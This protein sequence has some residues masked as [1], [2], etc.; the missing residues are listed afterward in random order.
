MLPLVGATGRA[1]LARVMRQ[2]PIVA[3]DFDG[4][5]APIVPLPQDA[6]VPQPLARR[7]RRLAQQ[8]PLAVISGR[9]AD[10]VRARLPFPAFAVVGL[11]GAEGLGWEPT[12]AQTAALDALKRRLRD[13]QGPWHRCGVVVEDKGIALALHYRN[14][15]DRIAARASLQP[16]LDPIDPA[17]RVFGGKCVLNVVAAGAPDKADAVQTLLARSARQALVFVGD[18]ENDEPVFERAGPEALTIRVGNDGTPSAA[19]FF[20]GG[21]ADMVA[22]LDAMLSSLVPAD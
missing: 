7:L 6:R 20:I 10:D 5:L 2:R 3:F 8:L 14:A 18:D 4:T 19:R 17:L 15:I 13:G 12:P 22:L 16:L 21:Q 1:A 11:H 9:R